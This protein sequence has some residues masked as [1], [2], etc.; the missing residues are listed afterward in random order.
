[1]EEATLDVLPDLSSW[2]FSPLEQL[3][4]EDGPAFRQAIHELESKV[5]SLKTH[6]KK[7][8][9]NIQTQHIAEISLLQAERN[10]SDASHAIPF[11]QDSLRDY[12]AGVDHRLFSIKLNF[13]ESLEALVLLPLQDIYQG[14]VKMAEKRKK[15]FEQ[16]SSTYY[17]SLSKYLASSNKK[18]KDALT[19]TTTTTPTTL[20]DPFSEKKRDTME[21]KYLTKKKIFD[22]VRFDYMAYL[23]DLHIRKQQEILYYYDLYLEKRVHFYNSV[24]DHLDQKQPILNDLTER[25]HLRNEAL[26]K[27]YAKECRDKRK[28]LQMTAVNF[29]DSTVGKITIS[30]DLATRDP[31]HRNKSGVTT[32]EGHLEVTANASEFFEDSE[33]SEDDEDDQIIL[34]SGNFTEDFEEFHRSDFQSTNRS[35]PQAI[36]PESQDTISDRRME[37]FL[38]CAKWTKEFKSLKWKRYWCVLA[39]GEI[40]EYSGWKKESIKHKNLID[41]H[42][43]MVKVAPVTEAGRR[44]CFHI[45][46]PAFHRIYQATSDELQLRWVQCIQNTIAA[47]LEGSCSLYKVPL[48]NKSEESDSNLATVV[49][50]EMGGILKHEIGHNTDVDLSSLAISSSSSTLY[51][52]S[53]ARMRR[54]EHRNKGHPPLIFH[55]DSKPPKIHRVALPLSSMTSTTVVPGTMAEEIPMVNHGRSFLETLYREDVENQHCADC[56]QYLPEWCSI[57]LGLLLCIQCAGIH[58]SLGSHISKVRSFLLD[59]VCFTDV[60]CFSSDSRPSDLGSST[61]PSTLLFFGNKAG[62]DVWEYKLRRMAT[63]VSSCTEEWPVKPTAHSTVEVKCSFIHAKYSKKLFYHHK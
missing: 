44:F 45:I 42:F 7:L 43:C 33:D 21:E 55:K 28:K 5:D 10:L 13:I 26:D 14:H 22:L 40:R 6:L 46:S 18:D 63:E 37:G 58:R 16:E 17:A 25:V 41:L 56:N 11:L 36:R 47:I 39:C 53:S 34:E 49:S 62:N 27:V 3:Q 32:S 24:K 12:Q 1:M 60:A 31:L 15:E 19:T 59:S 30:V 52:Q 51:S 61:T 9:K 20:N 4:L 57:N 50:D 2:L 48:D 29:S 54:L 38:T 8:I 35:E 23:Q